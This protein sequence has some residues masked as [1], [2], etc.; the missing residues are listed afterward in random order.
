MDFFAHQHVCFR[1]A[2][3]FIEILNTKRFWYNIHKLCVDQINIKKE[4]VWTKGNIIDKF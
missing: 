1:F 2:N 4:A 3:A